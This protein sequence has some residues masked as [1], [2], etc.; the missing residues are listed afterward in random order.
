M[1]ASIAKW[2]AT[3]SARLGLL[4]RNAPMTGPTP[5]RPFAVDGWT[6]A[7]GYFGRSWQSI[8]EYSRA[9]R[10][11]RQHGGDNRHFRDYPLT[12]MLG[13]IRFLNGDEE[14]LPLWR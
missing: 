2:G 12:D 8:W 5:C 7:V 1:A 9:S 4:L 11:G 14:L 3:V 13:T 10:A 6:S